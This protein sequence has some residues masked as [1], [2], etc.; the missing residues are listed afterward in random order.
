MDD[1]LECG[2]CFSDL[3]KEYHDRE[4]NSVYDDATF[5]EFL[6]LKETFQPGTQL[7]YR[8]QKENFKKKR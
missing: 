8:P 6:I 4:W 1:Q 3:Y 7:D 5:F 2:W